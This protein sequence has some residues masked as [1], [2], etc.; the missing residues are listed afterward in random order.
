MARIMTIRMIPVIFDGI[1]KGVSGP[2]PSNL[3]EAV[4]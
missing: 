4:T 1:S 3:K 2:S